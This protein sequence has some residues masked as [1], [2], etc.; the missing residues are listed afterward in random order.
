M[1]NKTPHSF[2]AE[3]GVLG[4]L[5]KAGANENVLAMLDQSDFYDKQHAMFYGVIQQI[6][7]EGLPVDPTVIMDRVDVEHMADIG[8]LAQQT[9]SAANIEAY[10]RMVANKSAERQTLAMLH[11]QINLIQGEWK[12]EDI[13]LLHTKEPL[14]D[15]AMKCNTTEGMQTK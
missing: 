2:E 4:S 10:A 3:Q 6:H 1:E 9:P 15:G 5:I 11:E 7:S 8:T 13:K 14:Q 12:T